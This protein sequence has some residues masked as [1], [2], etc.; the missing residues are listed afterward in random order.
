MRIEL[1]RLKKY[2]DKTEALTK[3]HDTKDQLKTM[4]NKTITLQSR[5]RKVQDESSNYRNL[6]TRFAGKEITLEEF[7]KEQLEQTRKVYHEEIERKAKQ[8]FEAMAPKLVNKELERT[9]KLPR[10]ERSQVL[11]SIVDT[12]VNEN[13][14]HVLKTPSSWPLWFKQSV[15]NDIKEGIERGLDKIFW[16][17]VNRAKQAEW[18]EFL[19]KYT[20]EKITPICQDLIKTHFI[21][22]LADQS[23][24]ESCDKCEMVWDFSLSPENIALLF[25]RGYI[26]G[27]CGNPQ[28]V[29]WHRGRHK[30]R[31]PLADLITR[32]VGKPNMP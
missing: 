27:A 19:E 9:L 2:L 30:I 4:E 13:V 5:L 17:N 21:N 25:R 6:K 11:N 28:C 7:M 32:F 20:W 15:D 1:D 24:V 22:V 23:I 26:E 31:I 18:P 14:N 8:K 29:E 10:S 12:K 16:A 3:Y